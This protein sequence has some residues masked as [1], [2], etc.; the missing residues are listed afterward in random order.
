VPDEWVVAPSSLPPAHVHALG[1]ERASWSSSGLRATLAAQ[2][3]NSVILAGFWLE[4]TVTFVALLALAGGL[5]VFV[6]MDASPTWAETAATAATHRLLHSGAVP[7]T[8][9][10]LIA[11]W[12]EASTDPEVRAA[13]S[14]ANE[15]TCTGQVLPPERGWPARRRGWRM[16]SHWLARHARRRSHE[17]AEA[18]SA[19]D[20]GA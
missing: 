10:Q 7:I 15:G 13:L 11:E 3:R 14:R 8:T 4:T 19:N 6:L 18:R 17:R 2:N 12:M 5:E 1:T 20:L 9:Y 16:V